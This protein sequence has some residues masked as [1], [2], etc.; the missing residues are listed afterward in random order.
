MWSNNF[1]EAIGLPPIQPNPPVEP[2]SSMP[3][4]PIR[5]PGKRNLGGNELRILPFMGTGAP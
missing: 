3:A 1:R 4:P 2:I 5:I